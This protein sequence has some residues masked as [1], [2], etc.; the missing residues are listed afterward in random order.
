MTRAVAFFYGSVHAHGGK[1]VAAA[2]GGD[3]LRGDIMSHGHSHGGAE[4]DNKMIAIL[5]SVLALLLAVS[6]T[7]GKSA[8]TDALKYNVEASNLW[9]FFQAKTIRKTT[10]ETAAEQMEIDIQLAKDPAVKD[11]LEKRV[12]AWKTRAARYESEPETQEG[13]K[14]L[15][16]RANALEAK[17][18]LA[19]AKYH[20]FEYGS[21]AFQ[22][23]IVLASAYLITEVIFLLWG[24]LG[25]GGI[26]FLFTLIGVVAPQMHFF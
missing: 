23:A 18:G 8:Q 1:R 2:H 21:A 25:I 19:F 4:G 15:T 16:A 17:S 6:E 26:G 9:S 3:L 7:L 22:I 24:A 13:R 11:L 5:I 20:N 10:M 14:E 12:G